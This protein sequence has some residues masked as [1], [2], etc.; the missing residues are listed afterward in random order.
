MDQL[1]DA[2]YQLI[3]DRYESV[4]KFAK[5]VDIP[6]QTIYSVLHSKIVGAS[7][8]TFLP[9]AAAL[10]L[11]PFQLAEGKLASVD[12]GAAIPVP[13]FGSIVAGQPLEPEMADEM[14]PIPLQVHR[15]FPRAFLLRI[16]GESMNCVLPNGCY[17]LVNPCTRIETSGQLFALAIGE[18]AATV[19]R[20]KL[21]ANGLEL[22]PLSTDPTFR[23]T[24]YDY[25]DSEAPSVRVIGRVVWYC[26]PPTWEP[27]FD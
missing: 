27:H 24:V 21:L 2:L 15:R 5:A 20:V 23:P 17:A 1:E 12:E 25:A 10:H 13:L 6:P 3:I 19:K 14:F 22:Q 9:I 8:A 7:A 18:T 11:D 4:P 16:D 26:M